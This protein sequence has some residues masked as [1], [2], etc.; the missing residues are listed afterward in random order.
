[1]LCI[2]AYEHSA[3]SQMGAKNVTPNCTQVSEELLKRY[4]REYVTQQKFILQLIIQDETYIHN[5]D[6]ESERQSMQWNERIG[7]N[8]HFV[9][10]RTVYLLIIRT[11]KFLEKNNYFFYF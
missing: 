3:V 4:R 7:Q 6:S 5:F 10:M 9:T 1:M 11:R 8:C 2:L